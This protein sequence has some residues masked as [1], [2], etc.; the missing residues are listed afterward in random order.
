MPHHI[1]P[2]PLPDDANN[3]YTSRNPMDVDMQDSM[4]DSQ[5][6]SP[7]S[8]ATLN[9]LLYRDTNTHMQ[10]PLM[11]QSPSPVS[12]Q[13]PIPLD[14]QEPVPMSP[15]EVELWVYDDPHAPP[16]AGSNPISAGHTRPSSPS[17][18]DSLTTPIYRRIMPEGRY[19]VPIPF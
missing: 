11:P 3:L 16:A 14:E 1:P 4:E 17:L 19:K 10:E 2:K 7:S 18:P 8:R 5:G 6:E 9:I 15:G 12:E 13:L